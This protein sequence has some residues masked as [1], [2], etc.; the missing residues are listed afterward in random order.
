MMMTSSKSVNPYNSMQICLNVAKH[1]FQLGFLLFQRLLLFHLLF[2]DKV[3]ADYDATC[4]MTSSLVY[5]V[6]YYL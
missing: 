3:T 1:Y 5:C 2:F 4:V 6:D